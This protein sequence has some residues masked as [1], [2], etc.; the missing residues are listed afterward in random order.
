MAI[1]GYFS[2]K[3][4]QKTNWLS[5]FKN[6][7]RA[8]WLRYADIHHVIFISSYQ[9]PI[10]IIEMAFSSL[11]A[12][13]DIDLRKIHPVLALEERA[14]KVDNRTTINYFQRKYASTFG[15][16]TFTIHPQNTPHEIAGKHTNEAYAAKYFKNTVLK[17]KSKT[18]Q[19]N[20][21]QL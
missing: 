21:D 15:S 10:E 8:P 11:A 20:P 19:F 4:A 6:D 16:L 1:N 9:E 5:R 2:I 17:I 12:Q 14:G 3:K 18:N 13:I 7:F